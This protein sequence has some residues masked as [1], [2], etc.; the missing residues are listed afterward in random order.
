MPTGPGSNERAS[1]PLALSGA[2]A[3]MLAGLLATAGCG[4]RQATEDAS[5]PANGAAAEAPPAE[6][7]QEGTDVQVSIEEAQTE[8][9]DELMS[10]PAVTIVGI[11]ECEGEP[12]IRVWVVATTEALEEKIPDEFKGY[13]VEISVSGEVRKRKDG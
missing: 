9:A 2:I 11:G 8:L 12:C 7:S 5:P 4:T 6:A 3:V 10:D 1:R 13:K